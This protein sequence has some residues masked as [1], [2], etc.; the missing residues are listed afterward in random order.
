MKKLLFTLC[1]LFI[2]L[3]HLSAQENK[4]EY[5]E[6]EKRHFKFSYHENNE[7]KVKENVVLNE[8]GSYSSL[9][10]YEEY[11]QNAQLV[12]KG[13][14]IN[15]RHLEFYPNGTKKVHGAVMNSKREGEW[16]FFSADGTKIRTEVYR[17]GELIDTIT[18]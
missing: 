16:W 9:D 4:D 3:V 17:A 1:I 14:K 7:I 2:S 12:F 11:D 5:K 18:Y 8:D 15:G 10:F 6:I 13:N